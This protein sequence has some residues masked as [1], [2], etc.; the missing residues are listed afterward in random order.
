VR[1]HVFRTACEQDEP[2]TLLYQSGEQ[3]KCLASVVRLAYNWIGVD[4]PKPHE[5]VAAG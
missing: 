4:K 5:S 1:R 3:R 2:F